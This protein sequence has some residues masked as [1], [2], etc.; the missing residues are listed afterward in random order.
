MWMCNVECGIGM[1]SEFEGRNG[2]CG[3]VLSCVC[4]Y[5]TSTR[6]HEKEAVFLI[7]E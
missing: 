4:M 7:V 5:S 3:S 6:V 1:G 2:G